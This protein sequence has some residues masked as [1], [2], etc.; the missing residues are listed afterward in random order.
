MT[1]N[2]PLEKVLGF[3]LQLLSVNQMNTLNESYILLISLNTLSYNSISKIWD[4]SI[5]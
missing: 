4:T 1:L 5:T 3:Y 2:S